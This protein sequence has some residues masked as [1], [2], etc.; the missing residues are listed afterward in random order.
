[1]YTYE[2]IGLYTPKVASI[3]DIT[4]GNEL[5]WE[6]IW[7][8]TD[9]TEC[10]FQDLRHHKWEIRHGAATAIREIIIHH[11]SGGGR[12]LSV[13]HKN[14]NDLS[15]ISWLLDVA[16]LLLCLV[17]NDRFGDF[18]SD[19]VVAPVRETSAMA[20]AAI[21]KLLYLEECKAVID[22]LL[23][24]LEQSDWQARHGSMLVI[25]YLLMARPPTESSL[26]QKVL[27][28]VF[29][30]LIKGL[31]DSVDDV[32]GAAAVALGPVIGDLM[33]TQVSSSKDNLPDLDI[34]TKWLWT[35]LEDLD[36][37]SSST[38]AILKLLS[39]ILKHTSNKKYTAIQ[40]EK[41]DLDYK[42]TDVLASRILPFLY[43]SSTTVR[44][45][46]LD[47]LATITSQ[48]NLAYHFLHATAEPIL[49]H[50]FQQ[51]LLEHNAKNLTI[52]EC[53]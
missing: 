20:I 40:G 50:L 3:A 10:L 53:V 8:F 11:G 25:K 48:D 4:V 37:L 32:V 39:T 52:L 9:F 47:T 27:E 24:L 49:K 34:I 19:E 33:Y 1:M 42:N 38:N 22:I 29:P 23:L 13:S 6:N 5:S 16:R 21:M 35:S 17:A 36:E 44:H 7:P 41:I 30:G 43:H 12:N 18:L 51:A 26:N 2:D 31:N 14:Q 15:N 28:L 45:S 46:A